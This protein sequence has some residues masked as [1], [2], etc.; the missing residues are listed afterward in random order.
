MAHVEVDWRSRMRR[1]LTFSLTLASEMVSHT[2][3]AALC[4]E[5]AEISVKFADIGF[6]GEGTSMRRGLFIWKSEDGHARQKYRILSREHLNS[7]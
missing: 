1:T 2:S 3:L 6:G 7:Y 5:I 4:D